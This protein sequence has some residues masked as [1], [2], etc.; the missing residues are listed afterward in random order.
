MAP[1]P[2]SNSAC[3]NSVG[4]AEQESISGGHVRRRDGA[5]G[6]DPRRSLAVGPNVLRRA[7]GAEIVILWREVIAVMMQVT[8]TPGAM[9]SNVTAKADPTPAGL[10][11]WVLAGK[12]VAPGVAHGRGL[13]FATLACWLAAEGLGAYMLGRWVASGGPRLQRGRPDRVS[14]AVIFGHAGLAFTGFVGWV[15]FLVTGSAALAWLAIGFLAPA[16]GL[17]ISTVT[18]WTP[19]PAHRAGAGADD[20]SR[21]DKGGDVPSVPPGQARAADMLAGAFTNERLARVLADEALTSRL[22]DDLLA[23]MLAEPS[24]APHRPRWN[25]APLIPAAHGVF[26]IAT[27]LLATLAAIAAR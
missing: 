7:P 1:I 22:V 27:F 13:G 4:S 21:R 25:L 19:Y 8:A 10:H 24:P 5:P 3:R 14:P 18:V 16:I 6:A 12:G 15:S 20:P 9:R 26:A 17:G 23:R 2:S 11:A